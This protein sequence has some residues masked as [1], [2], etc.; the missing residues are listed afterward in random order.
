VAYLE[1]ID[2]S[3]AQGAWTPVIAGEAFCW[4]K[5]SEGISQDPYYATH[6]NAVLSH[7]TIDLMAYHFGRQE[8]APA[9]QV[10]AFL[11]Q[12]QRAKLLCLDYEYAVNRTLMTQAQAREFIR[13]LRAADPLK[14]RIGLYGSQNN[15][16][17]VFPADLWGA[18]FGW[19]AITGVSAPSVPW[20]FWQY[21]QRGLD[22]DRFNG[23]QAAL[24]A[25]IGRPAGGVDSM[26]NRSGYPHNY[27]VA[28]GDP[29][30]AKAGDATPVGHYSADAVVAVQGRVIDPGGGWYEAWTTTSSGYS[31]NVD[32]PSGVYLHLAEPVT[33]A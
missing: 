22:H 31:D 7:G 24:D 13:R 3:Y 26:I 21:G 25:L 30:Y 27:A 10:A 15:P 6:A 1:G 16:W 5:A 17:R 11:Q 12:T 19:V 32:R 8:W 29:F 33:W 14:R 28:K 2:I 18:D 23:D 9:L 4:V 20:T